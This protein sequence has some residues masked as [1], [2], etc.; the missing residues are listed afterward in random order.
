MP[1]WLIHNQQ[2]R[3]RF[4]SL[5][6]RSMRISLHHNTPH[7]TNKRSYVPNWQ[8]NLCTRKCHIHSFYVTHHPT[9]T[10]RCTGYLVLYPDIKHHCNYWTQLNDVIR[11]VL[12][13]GGMGK[14]LLCKTDSE[15][16]HVSF[17]LATW[18]GLLILCVSPGIFH[19]SRHSFSRHIYKF[20]WDW[21]RV[22]MAWPRWRVFLGCRT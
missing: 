16:Y 2:Y 14:L 22:D 15:F 3:R 11:P 9:L 18:V 8:T 7:I 12:V 19:A 10:Y 6:V 20:D 17:R 1:A 13:Y 5:T 21:V 4:Q